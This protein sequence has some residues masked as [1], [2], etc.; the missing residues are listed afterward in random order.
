VL[1]RLHGAPPRSE[2]AAIV[3][4]GDVAIEGTVRVLG[5]T[6][7]CAPSDSAAPLV[8]VGASATVAVNGPRVQDDTVRWARAGWADDIGA[9][10]P[11]G[12]GSWSDAVRRADRSFGAGQTVTLEQD[13]NQRIAHAL[14][15]L[16]VEGGAW[17][18]VLLVEGRLR[19]TGAAYLDGIV[20]ARAGIELD[21]DGVE[22][23][24]VLMSAADASGVSPTSVVIRK[25][26][27][28]RASSCAVEY[29]FAASARVRRVSENAWSEML[30]AM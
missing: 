17:Q 20:I 6:S 23:N 30:G 14:G 13:P 15:D 11:F 2:G 25:T 1:V 19:V 18:G 4:R 29:A 5:D 27:T 28:V 26:V 22:V 8:V 16:T 9:Y 10:S 3:S 24:G 12:T 21:A 7:A